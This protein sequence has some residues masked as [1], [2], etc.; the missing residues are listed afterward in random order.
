MFDNL[1]GLP[2][3]FKIGHAEFQEAQSTIIYVVGSAKLY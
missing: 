1:I 3:L 2:E